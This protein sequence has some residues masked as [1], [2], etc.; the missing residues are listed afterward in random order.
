M[1]MFR[2]STRVDWLAVETSRQQKDSAQILQ[3]VMRI[4]TIS[5]AVGVH[6]LT[7][8]FTHAILR[9][10]T[11]KGKE[12]IESC[13]KSFGQKFLFAVCTE[14]HRRESL[15]CLDCCRLFKKCHGFLSRTWTLEKLF[16]HSRKRDTAS[17]A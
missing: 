12:S 15:I 10:D 8:P 1:S 16:E 11:S 9:T 14:T 7:S 4:R 13:G 17:F 3:L 6:R 2:Q 5:F